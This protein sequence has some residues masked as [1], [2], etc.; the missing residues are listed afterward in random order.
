MLTTLHNSRALP[1]ISSEIGLSVT[2]LKSLSVRLYV[3][4]SLLLPHT[5]SPT[6]PCSLSP[7]QYRFFSLLSSRPLDSPED[8][9]HK[10][11]N[12]R[13]SGGVNLE[14]MSYLLQSFFSSCMSLLL[15]QI[16]RYFKVR[17]MC[18]DCRHRH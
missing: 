5:Y 17:V 6:L 3:S 18:S 4:A 11:K 13:K 9:C 2:I 12:T 10:Q 14:R 1:Q 7:E 16:H 8:F 15:S